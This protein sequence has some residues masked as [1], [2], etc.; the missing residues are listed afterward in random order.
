MCLVG[1]LLELMILTPAALHDFPS[2]RKGVCLD[3]MKQLSLAVQ[4]YAAD[5]DAFPMAEQWTEVFVAAYI[6]QKQLRCPEAKGLMCAFAYNNSL[7]R[8]STT[9]VPAPAETIAFFESDKG[10]NAAGGA[11]L[12]TD[13]PRHFRG[14]NLGFAD[15][16]A[17]WT[18]RPRI[19]PDEPTRGWQQG[20]PKERDYRWKP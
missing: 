15:G 3:H 17:V 2:S 10:W 14:D 20:Y 11:E 19:N 1:G 16:H 12:L 7:S 9:L 18:L 6:D 4:M 13:V 8:L 5:Y